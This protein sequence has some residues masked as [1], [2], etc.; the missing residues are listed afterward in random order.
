MLYNTIAKISMIKGSS[1]DDYVSI[2]KEND[3][4]GDFELNMNDEATTKYYTF[5]EVL[6]SRNS[7]QILQFFN[8]HLN[9]DARDNLPHLVPQEKA[10]EL[11]NLLGEIIRKF[12]E[13][14]KTNQLVFS[15]ETLPDSFI[16]FLVDKL[17]HMN[18]TH[19]GQD[20]YNQ[21]YWH[22]IKD[23]YE[24]LSSHKNTL[25]SPLKENEFFI[26]SA[27]F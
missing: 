9:I 13:L 5:E 14:N 21:Y 8:T 17:P 3:T 23:A 6:C 24:D 18:G 20:A 12:D 22:Q 26:F 7:E 10:W 16:A 27:S 2:K 1:F 15:E 4:L 11:F 25:S 19:Y